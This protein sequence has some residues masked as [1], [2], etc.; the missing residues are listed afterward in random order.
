MEKFVWHFGEIEELFNPLRKNAGSL[1]T[2]KG[3]SIK[4]FSN[5]SFDSPPDL[6]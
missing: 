2:A 3:R 1:R 5:F 4:I 6:G